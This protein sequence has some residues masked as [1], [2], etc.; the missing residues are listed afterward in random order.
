ML[1]YINNEMFSILIFLQEKTVG[2]IE[3]GGCPF[4]HFDD[5]N[6]KRLLNTVLP[7][8]NGNTEVIIHQRKK[9]PNMSCQL[10][11]ETLYKT[12]NNS[13]SPCESKNFKNPCQYYLSL[14][15]FTQM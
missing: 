5:E 8:D 11:F 10:L 14:K 3:E 7:E 9:D 13:K 4:T 12:V 1:T 6:L 2:P 15:D